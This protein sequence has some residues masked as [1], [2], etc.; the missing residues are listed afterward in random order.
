MQERS[1]RSSI[2]I[3]V[4][5]AIPACSAQLDSTTDQL[6]P[7]IEGDRPGSEPI[8]DDHETTPAGCPDG[9]YP[10]QDAEGNLVC[11][12][13]ATPSDDSAETF[14]P[15]MPNP[16]EFPD[17]E[18]ETKT[19]PDYS[20][21]TECVVM[22]PTLYQSVLQPFKF[23]L[24]VAGVKVGDHSTT[25]VI[26]YRWDWDAVRKVYLAPVQDAYHKHS[27]HWNNEDGRLKAYGKK[28]KTGLTPIDG[29]GFNAYEAAEVA[30]CKCDVNA[31]HKTP[32]DSCY[33]LTGSKY[34]HVCNS[35]TRVQISAF[36]AASPLT[37]TCGPVE[38]YAP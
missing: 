10:W 1:I 15:G 12:Q 31:G 6:G 21:T 38:A 35:D 37:V 29:V 9:E 36:Q 17:L 7:V 19:L 28:L 16:D 8:D 20:A 23:D 25:E 3:L 33:I 14:E 5:A 34:G 11:A 30:Y 4:L 13:P 24:R 26:R 22:K 32:N 27:N 2:S 18:C